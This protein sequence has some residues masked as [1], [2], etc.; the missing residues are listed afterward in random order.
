MCCPTMTSG[1]N[2][3][4][5]GYRLLAWEPVLQRTR[6]TTTDGG[7]LSCPARPTRSDAQAIIYLG[8]IADQHH[9]ETGHRVFVA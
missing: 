1:L 8:L 5:D 7:M 4:R 6:T 9:F 3:W 2:D